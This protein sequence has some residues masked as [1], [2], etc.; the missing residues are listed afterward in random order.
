MA[1]EG[2]RKDFTV[3]RP[4]SRGS[5][6][7]LLKSGCGTT[8]DNHMPR[9]ANQP[10]S[11]AP[12]VSIITPFYNTEQYIAECIE[13]VLAQTY[14]NWE[15]ILVNNQSTDASRSIAERYV[16]KD[17]RVRLLDT[18]KHLTQIENF[19]AALR[20]MSSESKYCKLVLADD[21]LFPECVE[22]MLALA[23][24]NPS[25]GI[26]SAYQLLG[27]E[28]TGDG[29]PYSDTVISGRQAARHMI[30]DGYYLT[31]SPS[32]VLFRADVVRNM[33]PFYSDRWILHGDTE[34]CFRV[35]AQ[36]EL[37]FI[38][39]VLTFL[40]KDSESVSAKAAPLGP[41]PVRKFLFAK[42]FGPQF[43]SEKECRENL[44]RQ[45]DFY[46]Q[47]LAQSVLQRKPNH[48]WDFHRRCLRTV[49][50]SFW[51]LGLPKYI[52]FE[53]L[54]IVFNP[55]KTLGRLLRA[56]RNSSA[57]EPKKTAPSSAKE[58]LTNR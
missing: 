26:V 10:A 5:I 31:G 53:L 4:L 39:Q 13:S 57:G 54:D 2:M 38:H 21:W 28:V 30:V 58:Q 18:P 12:L 34:A 6:P 29:L 37:G 17:H 51:D 8:D 33:H 1:K 48:F 40:R 42:S 45:T 27:E 56:A 16:R 25:V 24:A 50:V 36:H 15:Y 11:T 44:Q 43:L 3:E 46:G 22:R 9:D 20:Y 19:D 49:G 52:F 47:F 35:L 7:S 32:S 41:G 14:S 55:K 23:E